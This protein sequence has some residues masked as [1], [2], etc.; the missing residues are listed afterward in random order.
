MQSYVPLGRKAPGTT[1]RSPENGS[2]LEKERH[3]DVILREGPLRGSFTIYP[4]QTGIIICDGIVEYVFEGEKRNLPKGELRTYVVST[5]PFKL[6]FRFNAPGEPLRIGDIVPDPPLLTADGQHITGRID[7][8]L[9]VMAQGVGGTGSGDAHENAHRLLQMLGL[10]GEVVTKSD[11]AN[12]IKGELLPRLLSLDLRGYTADELR[13]NRHLLR[14]VSSPLKAELAL[15]IDRLGLQLIDFLL[16]WDIND[17]KRRHHR[18]LHPSD[19][20]IG[21]KGDI[22]LTPLHEAALNGDTETVLALVS[23]GADIHARSMGDFTPLHLAA[24]EGQTET[25]L[26]LVSAGADI[27]AR[28]RCAAQHPCTWAATARP[29]GDS[30]STRLCRCRYPREWP[31]AGINTPAHGRLLTDTLK[32]PWD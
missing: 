21:E 8:T 15:T 6:A 1:S 23:A 13:S 31:M 9:S 7:L 22:G 11:V 20:E 10:D 30:P 4:Y 18:E 16:N 24:A 28:S 26:A 27:H 32:R 29:N 3:D 5:A 14:D 2:Y 12:V 19:V 25:A 17:R